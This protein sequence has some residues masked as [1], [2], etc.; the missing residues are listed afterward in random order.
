MTNDLACYKGRPRSRPMAALPSAAARFFLYAVSYIAVSCFWAPLLPAAAQTSPQ[1]SAPSG[2]SA[3]DISDERR[4]YEALELLETDRPREAAKILAEILSRNPGLVRV[5]L[6]LARAYLAY[7][8]WGR[9]R[10]EFLSVLSGDIPEPVRENILRFLRFI[11]ARRGF[12]WHAD[13]SL[14]RLGTTANFDSNTLENLRNSEPVLD[15]NGNLVLDE[16]GRP[17]FR[18]TP[19]TLNRDDENALGLGFNLSLSRREE[20]PSLSGSDYGALGFGRIFAFGEKGRET[21]F[22]DISFGAE[23]GMRFVWPTSSITVAPSVT[24]RGLEKAT[25]DDRVGARVTFQQRDIHGTVYSFSPSWYDIH[26]PR[27]DSRDGR[28]LRL[29]ASVSHPITPTAS[30]GAQLYFEDREGDSFFDDYKRHRLTLFGG[31]DVGFGIGLQPSAYIEHRTFDQ[32]S[33]FFYVGNLSE[34]NFGMSLTVDSSRIILPNGF[35]PYIRL[36]LDR[37]KSTDLSLS[38]WDRSTIIGFER[39]F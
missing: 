23:V 12:D 4:F 28:S 24:R 30:L 25:F 27:N 6:E 16:D 31:F 3:E 39:R 19:F 29:T 21:D 9:A 11:D 34:R 38:Y 18:S 1:T 26:S 36:G 8:R 5:R 22:D 15:E 7:E 35:T 10:S 14:V 20:L 37:V 2:T 32:P 33:P 17:L 13:F